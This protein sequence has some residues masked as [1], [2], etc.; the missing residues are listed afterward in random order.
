MINYMNDFF[1]FY[2]LRDIYMIYHLTC[3]SFRSVS[4]SLLLE[5]ENFSQDPVMKF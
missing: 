1:R 5:R 4:L 2:I 3:A